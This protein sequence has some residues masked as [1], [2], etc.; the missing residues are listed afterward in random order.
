MLSVA[1]VK[2]TSLDVIGPLAPLCVPFLCRLEQNQGLP[3]AGARCRLIFPLRRRQSLQ[4][5]P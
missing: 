3:V 2:P 1:G 4:G 5:A